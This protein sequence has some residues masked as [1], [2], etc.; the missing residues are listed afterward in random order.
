MAGKS[1]QERKPVKLPKGLGAC[2]DLLHDVREER[3]T[4][5][6]VVEDM[7]K[8][9]AAI[10]NHIIDKLDKND[11]G[12]AVGKRYKA[13]VKL[14]DVY[15]VE[16]WDAFYAH[17]KKT[18]EFDLLNRAL[19]QAAVKERI[20]MQNRPSGKRGENWKPKLPPGVGRFTAKKLSLTKV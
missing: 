12:G 7:K 5:N 9:E 11:E 18:G 19:N 4:T 13:L 8:D 2:A 17:L 16:D 6:R 10:T 15:V 14:E 3:L 1:R 20:A